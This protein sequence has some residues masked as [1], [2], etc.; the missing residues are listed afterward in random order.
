MIH[1]FIT[2]FNPYEA[3]QG[4]YCSVFMKIRIPRCRRDKCLTQELR[5]STS[6]RS[7]LFSFNILFIPFGKTKSLVDL[8]RESFF[9][10]TY[11]NLISF[12]FCLVVNR[13]HIL[14][15]F[16]VILSFLN[17]E[18]QINLMLCLPADSAIHLISMFTFICKLIL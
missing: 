5:A 3:L 16:S 12:L 7:A 8:L 1:I 15:N 13:S 9:F 10:L 18:E 2:S 11:E 4:I 17:P 6:H 14:L